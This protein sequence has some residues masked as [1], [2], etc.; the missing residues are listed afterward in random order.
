M[1][2][3]RKRFVMLPIRDGLALSTL[4]ALGLLAATS[5]SAVRPGALMASTVQTAPAITAPDRGAAPGE[6]RAPKR[7][8]RT[9][10]TPLTVEI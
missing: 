6:R 2:A 1:R 9:G 8:P 4:F 5:F 7:F 10:E 3:R